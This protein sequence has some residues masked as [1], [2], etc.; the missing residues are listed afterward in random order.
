MSNLV[1]IDSL[2]QRK[3]NNNLILT[4]QQ[5]S[6]VY[7][8]E[9][10]NIHDNFSNHKDRFVEG[11]HYYFLKGDL[12]KEFKKNLPDNIGL[13]GKRTPSLYLWTE[14][15]ASRHCKI[16]DTDRAWDRF[17]VLE[18]SYFKEKK[19]E[20]TP[21]RVF[22]YNNIPCTTVKEISKQCNCSLSTIRSHLKKN[23]KYG[24]DWLELER[25]SLAEFRTNYPELRIM[26]NLIIVSIKGYKKL[27]GVLELMGHS[28]NEQ[29]LIITDNTLSEKQIF[30]IAEDYPSI[31]KKSIQKY[32]D[33]T[34]KER[35]KMCFRYMKAF[36][37]E[38]E[39]TCD[40]IDS[41][42][43]NII[44]SISICSESYREA[45][46]DVANIRFDKLLEG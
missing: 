31:D 14:R 27:M 10:K 32:I 40:L 16:L 30:E 13:V 8:C 11:K 4:T 7:E 29:T 5:L 24:D 25:K 42:T 20:P 18:E 2:V 41:Y 19:E 17:D 33:S 39:S 9:P 35:A 15:G 43:K 45:Y 3:Y 21:V 12:L 34:E 44:K 23:L 46:A 26:N 1:A 37:R 36:E 22:Y 28:N 38:K 6:E